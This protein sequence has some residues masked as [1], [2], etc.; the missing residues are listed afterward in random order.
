MRAARLSAPNQPKPVEV[1]ERDGR[2]VVVAGER[3]EE[4]LE[5][6]VVQ[7]GWW[8]DHPIHRRYW[9]LVTIRGRRVVVFLDVETGAWFTQAG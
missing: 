1:L 2:P 7:T 9:E 4:V 5:F 8:T 3:I 6:W